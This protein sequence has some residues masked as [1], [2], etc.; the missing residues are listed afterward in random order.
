M[1]LG[2]LILDINRMLTAAD[3]PHADYAYLYHVD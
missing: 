2:G 3:A 1:G